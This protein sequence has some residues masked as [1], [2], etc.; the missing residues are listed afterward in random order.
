M[1][2]ALFT[3]PFGDSDRRKLNGRFHPFQTPTVASAQDTDGNSYVIFALGAPAIAKVSPDG[4]T[5]EPWFQE[6]SNGSQRPG[7]T[8]VAFV[9]E[10]NGIV[11]FGGP[12]PLTLFRLSNATPKAET[13][14]ITGGSFGSLDGTEKI[15][16]I[17]S[18]GTNKTTRLIAAKAPYVFSFKSTDNWASASFT[19]STRSEFKSNS[20]TSIVEYGSLSSRG[21]YGTGAYFDEGNHGGRTTFPAYRINRDLLL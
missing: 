15:K 12:R 6:K 5:V 13:V 19:R 21:I 17:P 20:L 10:V 4:K 11:A 16:A 1:V 9:P 14:K 18:R 7:Y 3:L 8:G 2:C